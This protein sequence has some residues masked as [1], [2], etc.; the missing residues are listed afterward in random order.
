MARPILCLP[1]ALAK[2]HH[3]QVARPIR[4]LAPSSITPRWLVQSIACRLLTQIS[5]TTRWLDQS[6]VCRFARAKQHHTHVGTP[7][8]HTQVGLHQ[9]RACRLPAPISITPTRLGQSNTLWVGLDQCM[10]Y[11]VLAPSSV[12]PRWLGQSITCRVRPGLWRDLSSTPP[13]RLTKWH[14]NRRLSTE[15]CELDESVSAY[16]LL[17]TKKKNK[18]TFQSFTK[19]LPG[20][21]PSRKTASENRPGR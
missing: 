3:I 11:R 20:I 4:L 13:G 19:T 2:Q 15:G 8:H 14:E 5:I 7:I 17:N 1:V 16:R 9:S 10:P 21:S 18:N 12:T 6:N